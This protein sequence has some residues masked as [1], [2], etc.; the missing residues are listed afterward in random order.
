MVY[1]ELL[2]RKPIPE[3]DRLAACLDFRKGVQVVH[4]AAR[5]QT[6]SEWLIFKFKSVW[7]LNFVQSMGELTTP[8]VEQF[9]NKFQDR[10]FKL[11]GMSYELACVCIV[12]LH[13]YRAKNG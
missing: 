11:P 12:S 2:E 4:G 9:V 3:R 8:K 5:S 10:V 13:L 1:P 7:R 6:D